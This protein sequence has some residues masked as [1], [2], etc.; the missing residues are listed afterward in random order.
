MEVPPPIAVTPAAFLVDLLVG[1]VIFVL[2]IVVA[3]VLMA[4]LQAVLPGTPDAETH[5]VGDLDPAHHPHESARDAE[6]DDPA[7]AV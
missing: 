5:P 4:L 6:D 2:V 7:E 1:A 3:A